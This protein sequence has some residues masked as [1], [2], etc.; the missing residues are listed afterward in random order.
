MYIQ[1]TRRRPGPVVL[2]PTSVRSSCLKF[3]K[4]S[5]ERHPTSYNVHVHT[6]V[7][8]H[9]RSNLNFQTTNL[10]RLASF[11]RTLE[12][13]DLSAHVFHVGVHFQCPA[14]TLEC[15]DCVKQFKIT[16]AHAHGGGEMKGVSFDGLSTVAD[17]FAVPIHLEVGNR[18]LVIR[19]CVAD[20]RWHWRV[21]GR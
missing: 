10:S 12:V 15:R 14:K 20:A 3:E 1:Q 2:G 5:E 17:R 18:A 6:D 8:C 16:M 4:K 19:H 13:A 21:M 9:G 11:Q 7:I